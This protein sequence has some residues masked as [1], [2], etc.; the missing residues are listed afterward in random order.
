MNAPERKTVPFDIIT[1]AELP[2]ELVGTS[3]D[4]S[5]LDVPVFRKDVDDA[6]AERKAFERKR[7]PL[8]V[9]SYTC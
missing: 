5:M 2:A 7:T 6:M 9:K 3:L 1:L 8:K 4:P